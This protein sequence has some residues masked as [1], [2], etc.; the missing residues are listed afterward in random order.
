MVV[1]PVGRG[2]S[3]PHIVWDWN[4]QWV[5]FSHTLLDFGDFVQFLKEIMH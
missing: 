4:K 3:Y 1:I 5:M 2:Q